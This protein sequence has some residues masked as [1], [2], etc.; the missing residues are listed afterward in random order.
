MK[1]HSNLIIPALTLICG[2]CAG[3]LRLHLLNNGLDEKGLLTPGN[4][5]TTALWVL[6]AAY[7]AVL[8]FLVQKLGAN[9]T[10]SDNFP[11]CKLR[12]ILSVLGGAV[13]VFESGTQLAAQPLIGILGAL[14]GIS[15]V[16]AGLCRFGGKRPIPVFHI[17]VCVFYIIRLILSFRGW[18]S[19]PQLEDYAMQLLASVCLMLFAMHRASCDAD[20]INRRRTAFFG[21]AAVYFCVASLS[22]ASM[23]LLYCASAL[24]AAGAGGTL[25]YLPA[26]E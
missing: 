2:I 10:F 5:S 14:A 17:L 25:K 4:P 13:L 6:T 16:I 21:L 11:A 12:G 20:I 19:D 26:E 15:M 3:G 9:G 23:P 18:S 1:K 8:L 24:W 22:D 7:L